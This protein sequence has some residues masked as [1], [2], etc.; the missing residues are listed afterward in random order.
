MVHT[1]KKFHN[2]SWITTS[3][4]TK[5]KSF[6]NVLKKALY[7]LTDTGFF[8]VTRYSKGVVVS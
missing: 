6:L 2:G 5:H 4:N 3:N 8:C 1:V 7:L